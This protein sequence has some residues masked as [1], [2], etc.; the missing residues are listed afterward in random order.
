MKAFMMIG[1]LVIVAAPLAAQRPLRPPRDTTAARRM[2]PAAEPAQPPGMQMMGGMGQMHEMMGPMA[3]VMVFQPAHLL[4]R[5]DV[6]GLT[7]QQEQRL[8][9]LRD[10][11]QAAHDQAAA[12]ARRHHDALAQAFGDGSPDTAAARQHF[13]AAHQAM[14]SAHWAMLR[15]AIQARAVLTETQRARADGWADA[16]QAMPMMMQRMRE[17]G[18][19]GEGHG[20]HR[21]PGGL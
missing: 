8:T 9:A 11:A 6:L 13:Q 7:A 14:G 15:A 2:P 1:A 10:A 19:G 12:E 3:R 17:G 20:G 4:E 21:M 5:K 16:M 18:E